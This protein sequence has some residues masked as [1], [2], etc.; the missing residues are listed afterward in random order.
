MN[1]LDLLQDY[2]RS[3]SQSA[4]TRLVERHLPLVWSTARRQVGDAHLAEDIAQQVF[5]LLAQ[6]AADLSAEVILS[7]WLYRTT[8]HVAARVLRGEQRRETVNRKP[9]SP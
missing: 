5:S 7:G 6:K 4:F 2:A 3:G 1:D 8:T 9:F